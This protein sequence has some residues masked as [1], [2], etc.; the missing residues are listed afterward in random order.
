[1][2][3]K[4][5]ETEAQ[6]SMKSFFTF[7]FLISFFL[8]NIM[9]YCKGSFCL[10]FMMNWIFWAGVFSVFCLVDVSVWTC[11]VTL[12]FAVRPRSKRVGGRVDSCYRRTNGKMAWRLGN[13]NNVYLCCRMSFLYECLT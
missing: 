2:Y 10:F 8:K 1:M 4:A 7:C 3:I 11:W 12:C 13:G 5:Q 9:P 6:V